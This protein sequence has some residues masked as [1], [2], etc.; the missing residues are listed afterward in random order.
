MNS[1]KTTL[2]AIITGILILGF[3]GCSEKKNNIVITTP[4]PVSDTSYKTDDNKIKLNN[5]N[6]TLPLKWEKRG[7]ESEL[8]FDD[9]NKQTVGGISVVGNYGDSLPNHSKILSTEDIDSSE[10]KGKL[11]TIERSNAA[12][13][14]NPNTWNEVHAIIPADKNN[15]AYDIWVNVKKDTLINIIKSLH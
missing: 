12:A 8:F 3:I 5:L 1:L 15:M 11:F 6:F 2:T 13:S 7:N 14:N 4:K 10:G 9:E